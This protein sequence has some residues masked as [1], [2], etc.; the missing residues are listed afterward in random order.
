MKRSLLTALVFLLLSGL[1]LPALAQNESVQ[2]RSSALVEKTVVNEEGEK[3]LTL[4]P[5]D[6]VLPGEEVIFLNTYVNN[7][8]APADDVTINNS[9]PEHMIYVGGSA[10]GEG[11]EI[12]YS[13]DG[14]QTFGPLLE[15]TVTEEDG[16]E[17]PAASVDVTH[18]RWTRTGPLP[19]GEEA[20]VQFRAR[21]K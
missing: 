5:A 11:T 12:T 13:V 9:I 21:L 6:K 15:L 19:A 10:R 2:I 14:G 7:G 8:E 17:R 20:E 4:Q 3:E 16:T 1:A 18:I